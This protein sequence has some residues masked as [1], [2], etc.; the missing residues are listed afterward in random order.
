MVKLMDVPRLDMLQ[1][2]TREWKL[3]K[4]TADSN[5]ESSFRKPLIIK[6]NID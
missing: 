2:N 1:V 4:I 5:S 6:Q 3:A